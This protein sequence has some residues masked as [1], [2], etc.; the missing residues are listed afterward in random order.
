MIRFAPLVLILLL[1]AMGAVSSAHA[2]QCRDYS[3]ECLDAAF[4]RS[5]TSPAYANAES[6]VSPAKYEADN[7]DFLAQFTSPS[8]KL[9]RIVIKAPVTNEVYDVPPIQPGESAYQYLNEALYAAPNMPRQNT[10]V[11]FPKGTYTFDFPLFSNCTSSSDHQ[12][13]YVHWQVAGA[14]DLVIDGHGSTVNFSDFCLGMVLANVNRLTLKNFE[15]AWPDIQIASVATIIAVG[16]N[17]TSGYTYDVR[18]NDVNPSQAP[19]MIAG[20]TAWDR[21]ANHFDL[22]SANDDVSY[23]DGINSGAPLQCIESAAQQK[24]QGCAVK[25][26]PSYGVQFKVGESVL[27]RYYSFATAISASGNDITL[28]HIT[29]KNLIGSDYSYAQG[30]GLH[31]TH[32]LL[33]R[34]PG[35]PV[36]AVG[37]GSL[38]TNV[39]GDVVVE[40]SWIGYQCDDAFDMNTTIVRFT[41]TPIS[42]ST[43]MSTLTFDASTPNLLA[44]PQ[45][46]IAQAGDVIGLFDNTMAFAGTAVV[47]S[48]STPVGGANTVLTLDRPVNS[49]LAASGFIAGDLTGSAG[50]RYLIDHNVFA[51]NRAR[52]LLLQTPYG[53]VD[54]NTFVGQTLKQVYVLASQYWGEGP[55]A[56]ELLLTGNRFDAR[57]HS[58]SS[59]FFALDV[60]AE[61]AD[62][63][64][65]QDEVAGT[66]SP[67]PPIN[68]NIVIAHNTFITDHPQALVNV[69]SANDVL[70]YRDT[71]SLLL[72]GGLS[73]SVD[74]QPDWNGAAPGPR[75]FPVTVHDAIH[76]YFDEPTAY[77]TW[78]ANVTCDD[79]IMLAL[80]TPPPPVTPFAPIACRVEATTSGLQYAPR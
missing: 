71:L 9:V 41:P 36:S 75:Q 67:A 74:I 45:S 1:G 4:L 32:A 2:E 60:M 64:N 33:T 26:V 21:R 19:R 39:S 48:V 51:F 20:I 42:N 8:G 14:S 79:S 22:E 44:W 11:N 13:K 17:G 50:A 72:S 61:A 40:H 12:P 28:D 34:L 30:R 57:G 59:G 6:T 29:F 27:L 16:G 7:G 56:Q 54:Q 62:F 23:G 68:Q 47:Q 38:L 15:F 73:S 31:V 5:E 37:G 43:P 80:S 24:T 49:K 18:I 66:T 10:V 58:F 77:S 70:L 35:K 76:V 55:G 46:N 69:S 65:A 63:P 25:G 53:W 78:L 52:A 3:F